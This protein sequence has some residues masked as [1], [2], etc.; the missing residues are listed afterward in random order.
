MGVVR[1]VVGAFVLLATPM[2]AAN[3]V[4]EGSCTLVDAVE[5][6]NAD[7]DAGGLCP[8]GGSGADTLELTSDVTLT[9]L[10]NTTRGANGLPVIDSD[11]TI[12]GSGHEI[13]RDAAAPDF[14]LF[15][16]GVGARLSLENVTVSHGVATGGGFYGD[17][18]GAIISRYATL[19]LRDA[20]LANNSA[21]SG[22]ALFGYG[23]S[24]AL[25]GST[26]SQNSAVDMGGGIGTYLADVTVTNSTLSS[27][28]AGYLG[29][30][31]WGG[32][33]SSLA[34][35]HTTI[36]ANSAAVGGGISDFGSFS[37]PIDARGAVF[38]YNAG[39][40][41]GVYF[42]DDDGGNFDD[43]GTCGVGGV[44][45]GLDPTVADNGGATR[46]HA[47]LA[48]SS[49]IDGAGP[50]GL[51]NDQR[52]LPRDAVCDGGSVEFGSAAVGGS[53]FGLRVMRVSCRNLETGQTVAIP[54]P[55]GA[56]SC[57]D[58]GLAVGAGDRVR[59]E[60]RGFQPAADVGGTAIGVS[61][62]RVRCENRS[63][64]EGIRFEP[65]GS[66]SWSCVD[67]GLGIGSGDRIV[68]TFEGRAD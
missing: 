3:I 23:S 56:W 68:Q 20:T 61:A 27:N 11:I 48:G 14:R 63:T 47:V 38:G 43:D 17:V 46:T 13:A 37:I 28:S 29:G 44:L 7:D 6:A 22:G 24:I 1:V 26:L 25:V 18:G 12:A 64:G 34:L 49:A 15:Y 16:V 9:A 33:A 51:T 36:A 62:P 4:V 57:E 67:Q 31:F 40:S 65:G 42:L 58:A 45:T 21:E 59:Q 54:Q 10:H 60:V 8:P 5:A 30:G 55:E 66:L 41:C 50:C 32:Y 53:T 35:I 19:E 2:T 39:G 52:G